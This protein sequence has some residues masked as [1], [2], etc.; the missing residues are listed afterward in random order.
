MTKS[1]RSHP[2]VELVEE[3]MREGMQIESAD[4][5]A[6]A[7]IRLLDALSATGLQTIVVGSFVSPKW[8][9]QMA[10]VEEVIEG[11]SPAHGV[12]YTALVLNAKG[13]ERRAAFAPKLSLP[14]PRIGQ[15]RIHLDDVFVQRNTAR[16]MQDEID[17]LGGVI[18]RAVAAGAQEAQVSVN[19]CWGSNW[20]GEIGENRRMEVLQ[21]QIDAWEAAGVPVT[22]IHFGD[23]M[24][25]NTPAA[26]RSQIKRVLSTWP[27]I[28][29]FQLHLHNARGMAPLSAYAAL[30]E[31][32][33]RHTLVVDTAIGGLGGCP[34]CGNG[35]ATR[36]IPTE[37]FV[38]FLE[39]EGIDTGIDLPALIEAALLAEEV[40]GHELWG[41]VSKA[42]PRP[43]G[44]DVYA[45]DMP[46]IE[47]FDQAQ[48]F[49][50]GPSA[51]DG[52]LAPW[53]EPIT[54]SARD[55]FEESLLVARGGHA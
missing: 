14:D 9:P 43:Y 42:G 10:N 39:S 21:L 1:H 12:R 52:A 45:M 32:D 55:S 53:K 34:Y 46:F 11:F 23:P 35:R 49:R 22:R 13:V 3:S 33:E 28:R 19:A 50:V 20:I 37:D 47:T 6:E 51:Y 18:A 17:D 27:Q 8:V 41:H 26:M 31:L 44:S 54:S 5:P 15:S 7:K 36:M 2:R 4:I 48:H 25:W 38:H 29:H 30:C 24:S 40:V 16:T